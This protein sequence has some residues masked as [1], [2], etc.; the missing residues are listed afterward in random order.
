MDLEQKL[1]KRAMRY[2]KL[3]CGEILR[4]VNFVKA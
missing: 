2:V 4:K 3:E 1:R